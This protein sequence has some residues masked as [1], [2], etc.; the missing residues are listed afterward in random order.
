[1]KTSQVLIALTVT[2]LTQS[3]G[4]L[5][6]ATHAAGVGGGGGGGGA[7]APAPAPAP[8]A[9]PTPAPTPA[10]TPVLNIPPPSIMTPGATPGLSATDQTPIPSA[11][12]SAPPDA[13]GTAWQDPGLT[14]DQQAKL[15]QAEKDYPYSAQ[16]LSDLAEINA[17]F[18]SE[19]NGRNTYTEDQ[20]RCVFGFYSSPSV[21]L[22][23]LTETPQQKLE[24]ARWSFYNA[25]QQYE[26]WIVHAPNADIASIKSY[27]Q[28]TYDNFLKPYFGTGLTRPPDLLPPV[29][30]VLRDAPNPAMGAGAW[31]AYQRMAAASADYYRMQ[32]LYFGQPN[33]FNQPYTNKYFTSTA[34]NS[35]SSSSATPNTN[36]NTNTNTSTDN[37]NQN[38][39]QLP[40]VTDAGKPAQ[41]PQ[42]HPGDPMPTPD[43]GVVQVKVW[44][45]KATKDESGKVSTLGTSIATY[46]T[47]FFVSDGNGN[48]YITT[49]AHNFAEAENGGVIISRGNASITLADN[50]KVTAKLCSANFCS[51]VA[52][53]KLDGPVP[54]SVVP[55][56][57]SHSPSDLAGNFKAIGYPNNS[58]NQGASPQQYSVPGSIT[59]TSN[60]MLTQFMTSNNCMT[61]QGYS[62]GPIVSANGAVVGVTSNAAGDGTRNFAT[63]QAIQDLLNS[64]L[65]RSSSFT[66]SDLY[67]GAQT[68]PTTNFSTI[69]TPVKP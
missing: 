39:K 46:G 5:N 38:N 47:G 42:G 4:F 53:L 15:T 1:M 16:E 9:D 64:T 27:W 10:P 65:D 49:A 26:T 33:P 67:L 32:E 7:P 60:V 25:C 29:P 56:V 51:D 35:D 43:L 61:Q 63:V 59:G 57:L 31:N 20:F 37:G 13:S 3:L 44:M 58:T 69:V 8:A 28:T 2:L 36:T 68:L 21:V 34:T 66:P 52:L 18:G 55:M 30:P 62:G 12:D 54:E 48:V 11:A 40:L 19:N 24:K 23:Q 6:S 14:A 17:L 22:A 41:D 45:N 50:T